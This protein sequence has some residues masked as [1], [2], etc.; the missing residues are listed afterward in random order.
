MF[1]PVKLDRA[2]EIL[3]SRS[4]GFS[5]VRL[6]PKETGVRPIMNLRRRALKMG[7]KPVLG[8]SINSV[9]APAYNVLTY[10]RVRPRHSFLSSSANVRRQN[11][12]PS[13]LG[14]T[15]FSVGDLYTKLKS[16]KST[17]PPSAP[18]YFAKLDVTAAFDTIPQHAVL[19]LLSTLPSEASYRIS[20]HCEVKPGDSH[21][22]DPAVKPIKKWT[23]LAYPPDDLDTFSESLTK[24]DNGIAQ[25]KKNTIFVES[26]VAQF[27]DK[28]EI[29]ALL[30]EHVLRNMVKIGKKFYRQKEGIPQGSVVSSLLC[31]YFYAHLEATH[32]G[33][34]TDESPTSG[35]HSL[36]L[37]LIDDFLLIT[38]DPG[39]AKRFLKVMHKGVPEY[40]VKVN[41][42]KTL[43]N[44]EVSVDGQKVPRIVGGE[45]GYGEGFP[46]CGSL[47]DMKTLDIRRDRERRRELGAYLCPLGV[48]AAVGCRNAGERNAN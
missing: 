48:L 14:S 15:L 40:G 45:E 36:L 8:M 44:F 47:V 29:L 30:H 27:R 5:Q 24:S 21:L 18:L 31:N 13:L 1:E 28:E 20:K 4:L 33:F 12:N 16:F 43:V 39:H 10:E 41:P 37:R 26:I 35:S 11:S 6:I 9:L 2:Q 7:S 22:V 34:L 46:Y 23:A 19:A 38:T 3:R 32:L 42:D 25:G 17:L